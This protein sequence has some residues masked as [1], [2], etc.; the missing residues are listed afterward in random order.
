MEKYKKISKN[1]TW[2]DKIA[3]L[4]FLTIVLGVFGFFYRKSQ[5]V[6]IKIRVT[7]KDVLYAWN[8]PQNWFANR[9][10]VGD[11]EKDLLGNDIAKITNVESYNIDNYTKA[12]YLNINIKA[13]YDPRTRQYSAR[14]KK[15]S[16]GTPVKFSMNGVSFDGLVVDP[17][18]SSQDTNTSFVISE[19]FI[20]GIQSD[21]AGKTFVEPEVLSQIKQGDV[22]ESSSGVKFAEVLNVKLTSAEHVTQDSNGRLYLRYDPLYKDARVLVRFKVKSVGNEKYIFNDYPL[23]IGSK[24]ALTFKDKFIVGEI[25]KINN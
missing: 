17:P 3:V 4:V 23:R 25:V 9:F 22:I 19:V 18:H 16:F 2:F 6:D 10:V 21:S 15:L 5:Y 1:I 11:S 13:T 12:V 8:N 20:R 24:P 14:G 7:D